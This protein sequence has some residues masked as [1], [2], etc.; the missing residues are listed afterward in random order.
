[1]IIRTLLAVLVAILSLGQLIPAGQVAPA[2]VGPEQ[3]SYTI[4]P[5]APVTIHVLLQNATNVYGIDVR[6]SFDPALVEVVDADSTREGVQLQPG[7][8]PQPDF[9]VGQD[10]D[11]QTGAVRYVVTQLNPTPPASGSGILFTLTVQ[12]RGQAGSGEFRIES[13][14]MAN[15]DGELLPV[16]TNGAVLM[17]E[18][19]D[20]SG[21]ATGVPL[22]ATSAPS[23]PATATPT[24]TGVTSAPATAAAQLATATQPPPTIQPIQPGATALTGQPSATVTPQESAGTESADPQ[25][26][27]HEGQPVPTDNTA[28]LG[29]ETNEDIG[30]N[31]TAEEMA[32]LPRAT[33]ATVAPADAGQPAAADE[34]AVAGGAPV[35]PEAAVAVIGESSSVAR[36]DEVA[37]EADP[38][39]A[40][41]VWLLLLGVGTVSLVGVLVLLLAR[42]QR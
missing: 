10:V 42:R 7:E 17:V 21:H 35:E 12:G 11:P 14:E 34:P 39:F 20:P 33:I 9:V 24:T 3:P 6:A 25:A 41:N 23:Q 1:M 29:G 40:N 15:R 27:E 22:G 30:T 18:E 19:S 4:G 31:T 8:I 5:G 32:A 13:V 38:P 28:D 2:I 36:P 26:S 37:Q 16:H